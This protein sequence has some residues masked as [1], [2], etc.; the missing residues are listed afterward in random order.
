MRS[1]VTALNV[2]AFALVVYGLRLI[3]DQINTDADWAA[4]T[5]AVG[6]GAPAPEETATAREQLKPTGDKALQEHGRQGK[7][8]AAGIPRRKRGAKIALSGAVAALV[9]SILP[10]WWT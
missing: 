8:L 7:A 4:R 3:F 5:E 6:R 1:T 9:A 2:L 10:L